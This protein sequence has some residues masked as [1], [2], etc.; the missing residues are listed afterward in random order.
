MLDEGGADG[1]RELYVLE[2]RTHPHV[3]VLI[4][5]QHPLATELL[6]ALSDERSQLWLLRSLHSAD[7]ADELPFIDVVGCDPLLVELLYVLKV[8]L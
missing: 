5:L 6:V 2:L 3:F 7:L 4:E 8:L 1:L